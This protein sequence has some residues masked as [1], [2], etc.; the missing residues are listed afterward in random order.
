MSS[1]LLKEPQHAVSQWG[2]SILS[3]GEGGDLFR[4]QR[5]GDAP[6]KAVATSLDAVHCIAENSMSAD[7]PIAAV[8]GASEHGISV[9][10]NR[11]NEALTLRVA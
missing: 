6:P 10:V 2:S 9:F 3:G 8:A 5:T 11:G 4:W 7:K 1:H